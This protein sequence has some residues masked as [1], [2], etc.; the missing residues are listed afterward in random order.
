M[1]RPE[2]KLKSKANFSN[3]LQIHCLNFRLK[4]CERPYTSKNCERNQASGGLRRVTNKKVFPRTTIHRIFET[5]SSFHVK[6]RNKT[7]ILG[8]GLGTRF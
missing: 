7:F 2:K 5:N 3:F 1:K 6:L 8:G 4:L